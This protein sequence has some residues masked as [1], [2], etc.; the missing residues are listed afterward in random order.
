VRPLEQFLRIQAASGIV[1]LLCA[2]AAMLWANSAWKGSYQQLWHTP[3]S[4]ALGSLHFETDLHFVIN[5]VLMTLFFFVVGLEIRREL[6]HGELSTLHGALLPV[7]A[8]VGG[9][10]VPALIFLSLN[11]GTPAAG[12]WGVPM[13]TDI[14]FAV[15][16]LALLGKRVPAALRV[17][18]LALA[19]IDDIGA[20]LVIA[21]FYSTGD[22]YLAGV[23]I[24]A[25][26]VIGVIAL[27]RIGARRPLFYIIPGGV[28]WYG[29][30]AAG[31]HPTIAG[32]VLGLLTPV[33]SWFG[34][35]GFLTEAEAAIGEFRRTAGRPDHDEHDLL[36]ALRRLKH[37]RREALPPVVRLESALNPWVAYCIMPLFALANAG[38]TL[39]T[40]DLHA[41]GALSVALGI[42]LGLTLGKP[43]GIVGL[44]FVAIKLGLCQLPR[45]VSYRGLSVVGLLGGIGFTM[46]LFIGHLAFADAAM[47]G[48][49]KVSILVSSAAAGVLGLLAG[50]A[51]L[52]KRVIPAVAMTADQAER[53]PDRFG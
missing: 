36:H 14:A 34:K 21:L 53:S 33:R 23:G 22:S 39:D 44:S 48:V 12:G 18:L 16:V 17:L 50:R 4:M 42:G 10:L 35:A 1:L 19:I 15:G 5:E 9:M 43:V 49:A 27:Q 40:I 28:V 6:H 37:A 31:I 20:I 38:V 26:G 41:L 32:V 7:T 29:F 25:S 13:A 47:L 24:A 3:V 8:A 45:G 30:L 52:P 2:V 46:A 51:V 11:F